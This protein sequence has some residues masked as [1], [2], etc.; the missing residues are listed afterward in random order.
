[1]IQ[2]GY[3][4]VSQKKMAVKENRKPIPIHLADQGS[5]KEEQRSAVEEDRW[6][7]GQ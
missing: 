1:L 7:G 3:S 6:E 2:K 5:G 4:T